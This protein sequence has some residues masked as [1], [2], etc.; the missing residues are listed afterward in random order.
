VSSIDPTA[1]IGEHDRAAGQ[2]ATAAKDTSSSEVPSVPT[3]PSSPLRSLEKKRLTIHSQAFRTLKLLESYHSRLSQLLRFQATHP[4]QIPDAASDE[5]RTPQSSPSTPH[6]KPQEE[7]SYRSQQQQQQ[8]TTHLLPPRDISSSIASNLASARGI[9]TSRQQRRGSPAS[10]ASSSQHAEG[11][12]TTPGRR[13][14]LSEYPSRAAPNPIQ[15]KIQSTLKTATTSLSSQKPPSP[16]PPSTDE[17]FNRFYNTFAPLISALSAPLAFAGLPLNLDPSPPFTSNPNHPPPQ[18]DPKTSKTPTTTATLSDNPEYTR[19]FSRA[20]LRALQSERGYAPQ[21][22]SF[23]VVP[24]TGHTT[25]YAAILA[26]TQREA[27]KGLSLPTHTQEP[28]EDAEFVDARETPQPP[29]PTSA[30]HG[31]VGGGK[32]PE[33]LQ[34]EN[35]ALR[36]LLDVLSK[37]LAQFEMGSQSQSQ[38]LYQSFRLMKQSQPQL[39]A[40]SNTATAPTGVDSTGIDISGK[41]GEA[42]SRVVALEEQLQAQQRELEKMSRENEK[43]KGV[44]GRYRERWEKLKEG[45][46]GRREGTGT[47]LGTEG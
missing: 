26:R 42:N 21:H 34:L 14:R 15:E 37:R 16:P 3:N 8:Q 40:G 19:A 13:P 30:R 25:S 24:T 43:L 12:L 6:P 11:K 35:G 33:E 41:G 7:S 1:A 46:R 17:P 10:P 27:A 20:A 5:K 2:Y 39:P 9:P 47:G 32:T 45:A 44:V 38:A 22:E 36:D 28:N 29:S 4:S 18:P 31:P 23:Y